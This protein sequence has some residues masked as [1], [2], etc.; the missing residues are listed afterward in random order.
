MP[1][2]RTD[3]SAL[4]GAAPEGLRFQ[5]VTRSRT[6]IPPVCASSW[7]AGTRRSR[8]SIAGGIGLAGRH[9]D[10]V[11]NTATGKFVILDLKCTYSSSPQDDGTRRGNASGMTGFV[12]LPGDVG[13]GDQSTGRNP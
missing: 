12:F 4:T 1:F 3:S 9:V 5:G 11:T 6:V 10:K 8:A 13:P 7:S 2:A